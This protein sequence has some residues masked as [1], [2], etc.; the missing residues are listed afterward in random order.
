ML[1]FLRR[2][3][4][5]INTGATRKYLLYAFGEIGLVVVGILIALQVNNWN[6][7]YK[8]QN[9]VN[10]Y[11][12][13][14][15][16]DIQNDIDDVKIVQ[17][18]INEYIIRIDSLANYTRKKEIGELSN[19]IMFPLVMG[20]NMYRPY[21]WNNTTLE[22]LKNSGVLRF[23]GNEILSEKIVEYVAFSEHLLEDYIVDLS[24]K[25]TAS[26]LAGRIVDLNYSNFIELSKYGNT[27]NN[28]LTYDF[29]TSEAYKL[30]EKENLILL[31]DNILDVQE[32][33]NGFLKLRTFLEI[34]RSHELPRFVKQANEIIEHLRFTYM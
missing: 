11:A 5:L 12:F 16:K 15:I 30:A 8:T 13:S 21:S 22:E 10:A 1:H 27:N 26:K 17:G 29:V 18:Q 9:L 20:D 28:I 19:L 4:S 23:K 32:M 31:T 24:L 3:R 25:E 6:E 14:L 33:V 7:N 2:I 34:R